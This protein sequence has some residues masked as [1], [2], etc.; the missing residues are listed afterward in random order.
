M[1]DIQTI[2]V[3]G[4]S[5]NIRDTSKLPLTGGTLTGALTGTSATFSGTLTLTKQQ[6]AQGTSN[7][8]P[9]LIIGGPVTSSHIEI[10]NDEIMAK[11]NATTTATLYLNQQGGDVQVNG[12]SVRN[13]SILNAGTVAIA[14][15]PISGGVC[16]NGTPKT[17]DYIQIIPN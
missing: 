16:Y 2:K 5:Y 15:L 10:D 11:N 8:G 9:A 7:N 13:G 1:A 6:D 14:R 3:G 4:T 17:S 12:V